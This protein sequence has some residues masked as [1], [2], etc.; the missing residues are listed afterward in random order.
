MNIINELKIVNNFKLIF[1][2]IKKKKKLGD[3]E[4]LS[5]IFI[6]EL[7]KRLKTEVFSKKKNISISTKKKVKK[8]S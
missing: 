2:A 5:K 8:K 1:T 4:K 7:K 6:E 3:I